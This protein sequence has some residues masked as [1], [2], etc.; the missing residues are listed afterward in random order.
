MTRAGRGAALAG[1]ILVLGASGG[2]SV[3]EAPGG[4]FN[5]ISV[6]DEWALGQ[7]LAAQVAEQMTIISDP[8]IDAFVQKMGSDLLAV[9]TSGLAR[10]PW[11]FHVV[12][13]DSVNAF[14][15]PGGHVY[16]NSGLI[17]ALDDYA[18][19]AAVV[20]HE[21]G[22]GLARHGT[23]QLSARYGASLLAGLALGG[24][25]SQVEEMV[26]TFVAGG[27]MMKFSRDDE[28]EADR[29][30]IHLAFYSGVDPRGAIQ[31]F[32]VL[33]SLSRRDPN[34]I[35]RFLA[36]HPLPEERISEAHRR[37]STLP[38]G[39]RLVYQTPDF[40]AFRKRVA[41]IAARG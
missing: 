24:D 27:A 15:I 4:G 40:P 2:C 41:E 37:I 8:E 5:L 25:P 6:D 26:A 17:A 19:L 22:H 18:E 7:D 35:E 23:R 3:L 30:G 29:T 16:I 11:T 39:D 34:A 21:A 33:N 28:L 1:L 10:L 36:S 32:E 38:L 9:A 13:D 12:L 14:N 20:G 31:M